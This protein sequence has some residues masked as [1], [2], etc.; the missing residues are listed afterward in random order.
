MTLKLLSSLEKIYHN[1]TLPESNYSGFSMLKNEVKSFQIAVESEASFKGAITIE[2][3]FKNVSIYSVEHIKSDFPM[4]KG[5]DDYYRFNND[6]YYPD[7][8]LSVSED[9]Q[10]NKGI[11]IFWVEIKAD[12]NTIG[13][14]EII[15]KIETHQWMS[16]Q[17][18]LDEEQV[19]YI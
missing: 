14:Q 5:A 13:K 6:G 15:V 9:I 4:A 16:K 18:K 3:D 7:L 19:I 17:L 11:N 8:L 2:S 10:I 12:E 1:D